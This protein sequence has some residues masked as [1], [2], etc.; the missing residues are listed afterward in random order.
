[1]SYLIAGTAS[2]DLPLALEKIHT[3]LG[4]RTLMLEGG[5]GINGA[6]LAAGL[7]DE[8]SLL[9]APVA[10]GRIASIDG[11]AAERLPGVIAVLTY[12][13][14]PRLAYRA[15]KAMVDPPI[16]ERFRVLQDDRIDHQGQPV[17]LVI[18]IRSSR[19]STPRAW[20]ASATRLQPGR[21]TS[22]VRRSSHRPGSRPTRARVSL[23]RSG[24][25]NPRKRSWMRK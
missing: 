12:R 23:G 20:C 19:P 5:G 25:V 3:R 9:I 17:A 2:I 13:N 1:M 8:V 24:A 7:I 11:A 14:A 10:S 4:V 21:P 16:G 22:R 6:L 15:H 18:P